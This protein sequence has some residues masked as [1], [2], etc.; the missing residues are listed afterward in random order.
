MRGRNAI[1]TQTTL[2]RKCVYVVLIAVAILS[3]DLLSENLSP[4]YTLFCNL[5]KY[6]Y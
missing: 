3:F 1:L 2:N 5:C 4:P 6:F